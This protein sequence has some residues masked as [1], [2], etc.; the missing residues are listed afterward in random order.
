MFTG[1]IEE[2]GVVHSVSPA[3]LEVQAPI[4]AAGSAFGDSVA[5]NGVCLTISKKSKD[6]LAFDVMER[7]RA[8]SGLG[9]LKVGASVNCERAARPSSF[10]GGHIVQGHVD[11]TGTIRSIKKEA[12]STIMSIAV[13]SVLLEGLLAKGSVAVDGV[14]LTIADLFADSFSVSLIPTTMESTTLGQRKVGDAVNIET[15]VLGKYVKKY[16]QGA[17]SGAVTEDLLKRTGFM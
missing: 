13:P 17:G 16:V 4:I 6:M 1:I 12:A 11:G 5:V 15:D 10:L 9:T 3:R 2:L 7:T 14:S 8:V